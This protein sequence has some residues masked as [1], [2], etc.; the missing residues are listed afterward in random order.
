[1]V[2]V[3]ENSNNDGKFN[4]F[5]PYIESTYIT[6]SRVSKLYCYGS[7]FLQIKKGK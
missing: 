3:F 6:I 5:E 7:S 2:G 4:S 1:M